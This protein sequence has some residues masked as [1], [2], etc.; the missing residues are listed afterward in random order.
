MVIK[1]R[2]SV[3]CHDWTTYLC[4]S[5]GLFENYVTDMQYLES[6]KSDPTVGWSHIDGPS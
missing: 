6:A 5:C 3:S 1:G 4:T 2:M